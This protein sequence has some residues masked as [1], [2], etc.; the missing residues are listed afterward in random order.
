MLSSYHCRDP[1]LSFTCCYKVHAFPH[2]QLLLL[3][4]S[5]KIVYGSQAPDTGTHTFPAPLVKK[6]R[7]S[8]LFWALEEGRVLSSQ[9]VIPTCKRIEVEMKMVQVRRNSG[10][11]Q[12]FAKRRVKPEPLLP[13]YLLLSSSLIPSLSYVSEKESYYAILLPVSSTK[14]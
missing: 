7:S 6:P 4:G 14:A 11:T 10:S 9:V 3:S 5:L 13:F 8:F 12:T 1:I 2:R